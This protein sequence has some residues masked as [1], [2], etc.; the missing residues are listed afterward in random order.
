MTNIIIITSVYLLLPRVG[1]S[2]KTLRTTLQGTVVG[3]LAS[4]FLFFL[5]QHAFFPLGN[6]LSY[7]LCMVVDMGLTHPH[8]LEVILMF[9]MP[10]LWPRDCSEY[11]YKL[12][13]AF[14]GIRR[15][16]LRTFWKGSSFFHGNYQKKSF[17]LW[18]NGI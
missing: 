17:P 14:E 16:L 6:C 5:E 18:D 10:P 2:A 15:H 7:T 9:I 8:L 13:Q 1:H 11:K 4:F 12:I 3:H